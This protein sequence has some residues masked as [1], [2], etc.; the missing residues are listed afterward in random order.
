MEKL[1]TIYPEYADYHHRLAGSL[2]N[3]TDLSDAIS[4]TDAISMIERALHHELIA[5]HLNPENRLYQRFASIQYAN[6]A[7][8]REKQNEYTQAADA[9]GLAIKHRQFVI[10]HGGSR[11]DDKHQLGH[12]LLGLGSNLAEAD[13]DDEAENAYRSTTEQFRELVGQFGRK[14][15]DMC[16]LA[17]ALNQ[18]SILMEKRDDLDRARQYLQ[19]AIAS[20]E[21]AL[22]S[23]LSNANHRK[24]LA[25]YQARMVLLNQ[26]LDTP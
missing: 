8:Q 12:Y 14:P 16:M 26:S 23:E 1:V 10:E 17:E 11:Y 25:E 6:L 4:S 24:T 13:R 22:R 3:L 5:I 18:W 7:G 15:H 20:E 21:D 2:N 9:Q 19:Q